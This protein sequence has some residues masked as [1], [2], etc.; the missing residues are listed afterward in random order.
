MD[1]KEFCRADHELESEIET[2]VN[3]FDESNG[4]LAGMIALFCISV[5]VL[6]PL[7]IIGI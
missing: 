5:S 1:V 7:Y 4:I 2:E 3:D 6:L